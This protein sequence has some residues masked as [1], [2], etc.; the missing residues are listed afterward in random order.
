MFAASPFE[1]GKSAVWINQSQLHQA[2][3]LA[4]C[5]YVLALKPGDVTA[6]QRTDWVTA[7]ERLS[8]RRSFADQEFFGYRPFEVLGICL[9]LQTVQEAVSKFQ[10]MSDILHQVMRERDDDCWTQH[11][12][13][14]SA[15]LIGSRINP[16]IAV[17]LA[18][19]PL[20]ELALTQ[21]L[22]FAFPDFASQ[23]GLGPDARNVEQHLLERVLT[24]AMP[25]VDLPKAAVLRCGIERVVRTRVQSIVGETWQVDRT[26]R[27]AVQVVV[28]LCRRFHLFATQVVQRHD[29]RGTITFGDEYDV[30]DAMHAILK[31]HFDDVRA[32]EVAPSF[33]GKSTRIDFLLKEEQIVVETKM[34]RRGLDQTKVANELIEDKERYRTHPDAKTVICLVYDPSLICKSPKSL[35]TDL[36]G[37]EGDR[38]CIVIVVPSGM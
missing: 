28:A 14:L 24:E 13:S 20:D 37:Q 26:V 2:P 11:L 23:V 22:I 7:L 6:Q 30:Q 12:D 9:G 36:S 18:T 34:L 31:L 3:A 38:R 19:S 32:E 10:W 15:W 5:G 25:G 17:S 4:T 29:K 33:A 35:E 27:D 21:W 8:G 16:K 1:A